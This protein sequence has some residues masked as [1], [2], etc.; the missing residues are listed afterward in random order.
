MLHREPISLWPEGSSQ[1]REPSTP[2][3]FDVHNPMLCGQN[4][5]W[6]LAFPA[7]PVLTQYF[8]FKCPCKEP[9]PW[10]FSPHDHELGGAWPLMTSSGDSPP[11]HRHGPRCITVPGPAEVS[12]GNRRVGGRAGGGW[13]QDLGQ[14]EVGTAEPVTAPGGTGNPCPVS[15]P[16]AP[17]VFSREQRCA[18]SMSPIS[19]GA[20]RS[21]HWIHPAVC[22]ASGILL[23]AL[24]FALVPGLK[25]HRQPCRNS[26]QARQ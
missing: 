23:S 22:P 7:S 15:T 9:H 6:S 16:R 1:S 4:L 10:A 21:A 18:T 13:E 20:E 25:A 17:S 8:S 3:G 2:Y 19:S 12:H 14:E 5:P 11:L 26:T 24:V